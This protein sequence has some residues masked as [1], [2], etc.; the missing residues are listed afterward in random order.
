MDVDLRELERLV[1]LGDEDALARYLISLVR[2]GQLD[3]LEHQARLGDQQ[4]IKYFLLALHYTNEINLGTFWVYPFLEDRFNQR[5]VLAPTPIPYQPGMTLSEIINTLTEVLGY[6]ITRYGSDIKTSLKGAYVVEDLT[7]EMASKVLYDI[8]VAWEDPAHSGHPSLPDEIL[9]DVEFSIIRA[10]ALLLINRRGTIF[11]PVHELGNYPHRSQ[12]P[13]RVYR[14][15]ARSSNRF[16]ESNLSLPDPVKRRF[17]PHMDQYIPDLVGGD[18]KRYKVVL[19]VP[20]GRAYTNDRSYSL[21]E[22]HVDAD[23]VLDAM[24][25]HNSIDVGR[26]A[27]TGEWQEPAWSRKLPGEEFITYTT[28]T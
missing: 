4:A 14:E 1:A 26:K 21:L 17:T 25:F 13:M 11:P 22:E 27:T 9:S 23:V 19:H 10:G 24:R 6:A 3:N 16:S 7:I 8:G 5:N 28:G 12:Q 15:R 2:S 20:T 18:E